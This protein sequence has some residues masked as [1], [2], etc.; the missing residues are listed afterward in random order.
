V[1][2]LAAVPGDLADLQG[3]LE[4]QARDTRT[5]G[6]AVGVLV[7]GSTTVWTTGVESVETGLP[8]VP[9]TVFQIGSNTKVYVATLAMQLREEGLL[10]LDDPVVHHLPDLVLSDVTATGALTVRH[11]LTH[12]SG[13][14][15]DHFGDPSLGWGRHD[16]AAYVAGLADVPVL[17]EPGARWSYCNSGFV[18]LGR[19]V[20]VVTGQ[21][22]DVALRERLLGP[23]GAERTRMRPEQIVPLRAAIGHQRDGEAVV[24]TPYGQTPVCAPAGSIT[25]ADAGDVLRF[26]RLHLDGGV[27]DGGTRL[28]TADSVALMQQEQV[29]TPTW[30]ATHAW[31]LG[32][33]LR[34]LHDGTPVIGHGGGTLGQISMLE[35]VPSA[36]VAVVVLANSTT[37]A[38]A[39]EAV[40]EHVL[41]QLTGSGLV[42][43][44]PSPAPRAELDLAPYAGS[45]GTGNLR[46]QVVAEPDHLVLSATG[47]DGSEVAPTQRLVPVDDE[48]FLAEAPPSAPTSYQVV[49]FLDR[50]AQG[51][52]AFLF[53]GRLHPR[54]LG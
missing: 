50:D 23:L 5:P 16:L 3:L 41:Q 51:R 15:G 12:T 2:Q 46:F 30:G 47:A 4:E 32:W 22:F 10:H 19:L 54:A 33:G 28:L 25:V 31:G 35:V 18:L 43:R 39:C 48:R 36:G 45:Y 34:T 37:S 49:Q 44:P 17:H 29:A 6:M 9:E 1:T 21:P 52:P 38:P 14:H 7:D 42:R 11:L 13:L 24:T 27:T 26:V 20:E 8:V 40:T 53:N